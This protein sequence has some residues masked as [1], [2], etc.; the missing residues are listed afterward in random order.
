MNPAR[1][2]LEDV[3]RPLFER[4]ISGPPYELGTQRY[5]DDPARFSWPGSYRDHSVNLAWHIWMERAEQK[6]AVI[7]EQVEALFARFAAYQHNERGNNLAEVVYW[8]Q[9]YKQLAADC[10]AMLKIGAPE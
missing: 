10:L 4:V 1:K 9:Q 3:E 5:P 2:A 8:R 6:T 7:T